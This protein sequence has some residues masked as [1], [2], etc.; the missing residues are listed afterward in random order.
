MGF[1]RGRAA[2]LCEETN[3]LEMLSYAVAALSLIA[4][5]YA[6]AVAFDD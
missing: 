5:V 1:S 3:M 4:L 2:L 6:L